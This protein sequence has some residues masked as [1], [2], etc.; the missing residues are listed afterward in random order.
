LLDKSSISAVKDCSKYNLTKHEA[1]YFVPAL[2]KTSIQNLISSG[3][4]SAFAG[5]I[6]LPGG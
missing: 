1:L 2:S 6:A 4:P 5:G 3:T